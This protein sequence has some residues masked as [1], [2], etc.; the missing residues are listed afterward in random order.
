MSV[1]SP[2]PSRALVV[3][4]SASLRRYCRVILESA[5]VEVFEAEDGQIALNLLDRERFDVMLL[6]LKMP[7]LGGVEVLERLFR[8]APSGCVPAVVVC[9]SEAK[10]TAAKHPDLFHN[11]SAVLQKPVKPAGLLEAVSAAMDRRSS[12]ASG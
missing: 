12:R 3:D 1:S 7:V 11:V 9:S 8:G 4:D 5:G 10:S 2:L 6:D